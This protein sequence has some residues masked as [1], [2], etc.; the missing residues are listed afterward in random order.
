MSFTRDWSSSARISARETA[1]QNC[2]GS[3]TRITRWTM[4]RSRA[5][6]S[7]HYWDGLR[8][9][10]VR[11]AGCMRVW[12]ILQTAWLPRLEA[13]QI[14][15]SRH[16]GIF[17]RDCRKAMRSRRSDTFTDNMAKTGILASVSLA[18][19]ILESGY[20][21][22]SL[23]R[24]PITCSGWRRSCPGNNWSGSA[25]DGKSVYTKQTKEQNP[26]GSVC[27]D[28][29][30][31]QGNISAS[32]NRSRRSQRLSSWRKTEM[33]SAMPAF[34]GCKDYRKAAKR[35][36]RTADTRPPLPMWIISA[37]WSSSGTLRS[38]MWQGLF[39]SPR[40]LLLLSPDTGR[41]FPDAHGQGH[42][43]W[44]ELPLWAF[45][46]GSCQRQTGKGV[47]TIMEVKDGW[48]DWNPGAGWIWLENP[49]TA[50]QER[51]RR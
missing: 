2:S 30:G 8:I 31:F 33:H 20:G 7:L 18:Q 12:E 26:D 42:Y 37:S 41:L 11:A 44:P 40:S 39:L 48:E 47:F 15:L 10:P 19:F 46:A 5:R 35:S 28:H 6:W 23:P 22:A 9:N 24:T 34:K 36:S 21:R 43:W 17:W 32:K 51:W 27:D 13:V 3:V 38:L 14:S 49:V 25:W 16:A 1:R 4:S 29:C 50:V 45:H